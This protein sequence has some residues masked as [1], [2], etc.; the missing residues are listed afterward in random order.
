MAKQANAG[1][2][3]T[4]VRFLK[5][6][7]GANANGFATQQTVDIFG[8]PVYCRWVWAHG[9]EVFEHKKLQLGQVATLTMYATNRIDQECKVELVDEAALIGTDNGLFDIISMDGVENRQRYME[10]KVERRV[11]G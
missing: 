2:L 1:E 5:I 8:R 10:I 9:S 11:K 7:K 3:R 6:T 4:R